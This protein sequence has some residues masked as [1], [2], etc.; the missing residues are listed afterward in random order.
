MPETWLVPH[1]QPPDNPHFPYA[2]ARYNRLFDIAEVAEQVG[3]PLYMK[4]YGGGA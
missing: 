3:Y 2:A 4:P 1:K